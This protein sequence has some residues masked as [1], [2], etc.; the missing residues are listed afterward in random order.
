MFDDDFGI[1][2][3]E[4]REQDRAVPAEVQLEGDLADTFEFERDLI[5][6]VTPVFAIWADRGYTRKQL[7]Y[8]ALKT[9]QWFCS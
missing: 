4:V 1:G 2:P 3:Y 9:M 6:A 7:E 8:I 5:N